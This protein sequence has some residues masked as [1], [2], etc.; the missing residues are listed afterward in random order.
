MLGTL[1]KVK[2]KKKTNEMN[3][4]KSRNKSTTEDNADIPM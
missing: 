1:L 2:L 3:D 4:V